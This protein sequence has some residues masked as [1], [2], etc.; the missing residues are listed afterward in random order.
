MHPTVQPYLEYLAVP[1]EFGPLGLRWSPDGEA[2]ETGEGTWGF[3][4]Q[5]ADFL[6]G[7]AAARPVPHFGH[8]IECLALLTLDPPASCP[9][10]DRFKSVAHAFRRLN[11]PARNAGALFAHLC[12]D[13]P[14]AAHV[15]AGGGKSLAHWLTHSPSLGFLH[16][17]RNVNPELPALTAYAFHQR[18]ANRLGFMTDIEVRHWLR[19]GAA[20]EEAPVERIAEE[21]E[22]RPPTMAEFLDAAIKERPRLGDAVP[23]VR[24]F[25]S[26]LS[27]PPRKHMPPKLP[28]GGYADVTNRGDP[29]R[30][31]P[32]QL[33]LDPD[34]FVRRF[35]EN[36]LLFFR[37]ED[38]HER[39][40]EHLA[41]VVDQG[42]LTWGPV[43]LA[44]G[45][46]VLAFARLSARRKLSVSVRFGSSP[47]ER[48]TPPSGNV[49]RFGEAL[50]ASDLSPH[51]GHVLAEEVL[52]AKAPERD[53]V[54]LT[55]PR[56]LH[57]ADIRR[58]ANL[59]AKGSRLFALTVIEEGVVELVHVRE[60]G[61]VPVSRFRIDFQKPATKA[62]TSATG[63]YVPWSG[64]VE[65]IP[66][67]FRFG[68]T[69]RIVDLA[70]DDRGEMLL[71]A[72]MS[73]F[74]HAWTLAD[75][76]V[77]VLPRGSKDGQVMR[78]VQAV[79]G[80][81]NG[82]AVCGRFGDGLAVVHYDL[83]MRTATLHTLMSAV[84]DLDTIWYGFSNLHAVAVKAGPVIRAIDLGT[85]GLYPDPRRAHDPRDRAHTAVANA[86]ELSF[87]PPTIPVVTL[88]SKARWN[89]PIVSHDPATGSIRLISKVVGLPFVPTSDGRPRFRTFAP[90]A[91]HAGN[92]LALF[93]ERPRIWSIHELKHDGKTLAEYPPSRIGAAK[94]SN[95]GRLFVRQTATG[96]LTV[97]EPAGRGNV[98]VT[99]PGRCHSN[100][101]VRLG[102]RCLG[103]SVGGR[104]C[105]IEWRAGPLRI[106]DGPTVST[107]FGHRARNR[108]V[109][110]AVDAGPLARFV[111]IYK[112]VRY[113][114]GV[115]VFGQVA[116]VR[117]GETACMFLYR[118]GKL[119]IWAPEGIRFGPPEITGGPET[120]GALERLGEVMRTATV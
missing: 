97:T 85:G 93:D 18:V 8:V 24:H 74:L 38:P 62:A 71:A 35:A 40:Q 50:E 45:A 51:P 52:D 88:G 5:V 29:S 28:I 2:L 115:D 34:D 36:E 61:V 3:T 1:A 100:L 48:F 112:F 20:P 94:L 39:R 98:L 99:R 108:L 23:L 72:T 118:R 80:V 86:R 9:I 120:P 30:L 55:H 109:P 16:D 84:G 87:A 31:L 92:V 106:I 12:A 41:L 42:V 46:A 11:R 119:S 91:Q 114:V 110:N 107:D 73:G 26:A 82:F 90:S 14:A 44:L 104:G 83:S 101:E 37:R 66:Y 68:L 43:R 111:A 64:D 76:S 54:L 56:V 6:D 102:P 103:L 77:E 67:P 58:L 78:T 113:D 15:P 10:P 19:H 7:Y 105:L 96:E 32:S 53:I 13:I 22:R 4:R 33:A 69:N 89:Q 60:G 79:V 47:A 117:R 21:L 70:F 116:F 65:T 75:G 57:E 49:E 59:L 95:D 81:G 17:A 25:V 27:L 63:P